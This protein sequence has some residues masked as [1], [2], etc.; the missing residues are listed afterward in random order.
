MIIKA[1][2]VLFEVPYNQFGG[3]FPFTRTHFRLEWLPDKHQTINL[4]TG[5][6]HNLIIQYFL[7]IHNFIDRMIWFKWI[8]ASTFGYNQ[9]GM[10]N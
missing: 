9:H 8:N 6:I 10:I 3:D 4:S 5:I 7:S 2:I 1:W